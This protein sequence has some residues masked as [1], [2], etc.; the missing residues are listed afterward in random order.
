MIML[1]DVGTGAGAQS[2]HNSD[3]WRD[4]NLVR[5]YDSSAL[6]P[7]EA[8]LFARYRTELSGR[9][10]ELGCG[11]GR[12]TRELCELSDHV[13]AIDVSAAMV[14]RCR[15][16][17][18][19]ATVTQR[20]L[21]DLGEY[22]S[23]YFEALVAPF[24]VLDVLDDGD[25]NR[26]L[27]DI[28]R[29]MSPGALLIMSTHNRAYAP[30]L[31][32]PGR[33]LLAN[34]R[35]RKLRSTVAGIVRMPRRVANH[36]RL[37]RFERV[38]PGYSILNDDAHDHSMLHY[39]I[40]RDDQARQLADHGFELLEVLDLQGEPVEPGEAAAGSPELHYVARRSA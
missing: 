17:C 27:E 31:V 26:V 34:M 11:A 2:D 40:S 39:Y 37:R 1:A 20:D 21:R 12:L 25:R 16:V 23:G 9:L 36:R 18:P 3:F 33:Q 32:G 10:L 14:R 4:V 5:A 6:R 15:E 22:E 19:Q 28:V 8:T 35:A 13:H 7:V 29:I 24:N 38:E 30:R